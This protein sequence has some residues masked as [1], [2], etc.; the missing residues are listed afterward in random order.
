MGTAL[1]R[2]L[3]W[4]WLLIGFGAS[5]ILG[6][7]LFFMLIK[8][9]NE[10]IATT[11]QNVKST[12]DAGGTPEQVAAKKRELDKAKKDTI[13]I[14]QDWKVQS[15]VYMPNIDFGKDV[16]PGYE[17]NLQNQGVYRENGHAYG[18]KDL[19]TVWG[20]W[21]TAWYASQWRDG[22]T[23][24]TSFPIDS[25]SS[26]PN[27]VAKL[28][29]L[30][31]PLDKPWEVEVVAKNFDSAMA[32][33]RKFNKMQRHGMPVIDRV[34]LAGNSP[35][36]HLTYDLRMYVIPPTAPPPADPKITST[37]AAGG[38]GGGP[39][40]LRSLAPPGG[41]SG[42]SGGFKGGKSGSD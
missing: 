37:T 9:K 6:L 13:R 38:S 1:N 16:L 32:H 25:F 33:L 17:G 41:S 23:N 26:D 5:L 7:I 21:V 36:L 30:Q 27:D 28:Q 40:S 8:P 29:S 12:Q 18:V 2:L 15:A 20:T 14:N 42:N 24:L 19:P 35:N 22:I 10:D 34:S 31:F 39:G 11:T 4:H 3:W